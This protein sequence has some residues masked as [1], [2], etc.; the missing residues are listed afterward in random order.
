MKG[1]IRL[2]EYDTGNAVVLRPEFIQAMR[3]LKASVLV[4]QTIPPVEYGRRTLISL[5]DRREVLVTQ[6][7]DEIMAM[8][9]EQS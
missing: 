5:G 4:L 7:V 8:T 3:E 9:D 6:T 1:I 2:T